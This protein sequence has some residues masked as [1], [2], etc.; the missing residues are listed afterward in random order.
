MNCLSLM[1]PVP[2]RTILSDSLILGGCETS[3]PFRL[4]PRR[5]GGSGGSR[6]GDM[7]RYETMLLGIR[8]LFAAASLQMYL[9]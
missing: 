6:I 1:F 5:Q 4:L 8:Y 9:S 7:G 3:A 2:T